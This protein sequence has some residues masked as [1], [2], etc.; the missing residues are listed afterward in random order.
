MTRRKFSREFKSE[1]VKLETDWA[2]R[3]PRRVG[4][5][6]WQRACCGDGCGRRPWPR[7]GMA[8]PDN[9]QQRA[10]LAEIAVL[11]KE[12]AKL[13]A[14]RDILKKGETLSAIDEVDGSRFRHRNVPCWVL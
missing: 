9:G 14:E 4:I 3:A 8:F 12:V 10:E 13:K 1:A 5:W 11:K 2:L 7:D 6:N